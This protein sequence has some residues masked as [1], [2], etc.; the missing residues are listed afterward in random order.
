MLTLVTLLVLGHTAISGK[1]LTYISWPI[2]LHKGCRPLYDF[3][4]LKDDQ[5]SV[6]QTVSYEHPIYV[7]GFVNGQIAINFR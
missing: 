1:S 2:M 5:I 4:G 6:Y 3:S 7:E